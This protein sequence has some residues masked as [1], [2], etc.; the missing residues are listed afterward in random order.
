MALGKKLFSRLLVHVL[1]DLYQLNSPEDK[2]EYCQDQY[3]KMQCDK[4]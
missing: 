2:K 4:K 3:Y 1:I